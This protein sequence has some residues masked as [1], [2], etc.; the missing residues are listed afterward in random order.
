MALILA[1]LDIQRCLTMAEA[2]EAI[3]LAFSA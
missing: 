1:R 2:I 3:R